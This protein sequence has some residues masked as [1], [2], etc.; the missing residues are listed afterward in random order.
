[1]RYRSVAL[2]AALALPALAGCKKQTPPN[3][4]DPAAASGALTSI[5]VTGTHAVPTAPPV[6]Q[7][8]EPVAAAATDAGT[9]SGQRKRRSVKGQHAKE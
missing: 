9:T 7:P 5:P 2:V 6:M 4:A 3:D 1:M 8:D